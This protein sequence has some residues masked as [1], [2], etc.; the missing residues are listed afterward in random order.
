MHTIKVSTYKHTHTHIYT[1]KCTHDF[2]CVNICKRMQT[3]A[4]K[5]LPHTHY[6]NHTHTTT[7]THTH[8]LHPFLGSVGK[9][10]SSV[11]LWVVCVTKSFSNTSWSRS[12]STSLFSQRVLQGERRH[13]CSVIT[14]HPV[15]LSLSL[16]LPILDQTQRN[17]F[18]Q[19]PWGWTENNQEV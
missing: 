5:S 15:S 4:K 2:A 7:H 10:K 18:D 6:H 19:S 17:A 1:Q 12:E 16:S 9:K 11:G 14:A 13:Q 8:T 3:E